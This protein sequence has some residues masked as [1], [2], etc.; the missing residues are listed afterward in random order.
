MTETVK[1][2][3]L[4]TYELCVTALGSALM[5]ICAWIAIPTAVPFTLQTFAVFLVT[6]LLGLKCGTLSVLVYLL[7]GAVGLPVFTGFKGGIGA[8]LGTTGGYLIG[9]IFTALCIGLL[10]K[11][12]G[13]SLPVLLLSMAA[14]MVLCYAFGSAWFLFLYTQATGPIALSSVLS[15]CV[16]PFLLPDAVKILLAALLTL[17]LRRHLHMP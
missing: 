9:F 16:I 10:T 14:G 15:M 6:G 11:Y 13:R 1:R 12:L 4:T 2:P 5:A 8:L 7:L 17:R 3:W